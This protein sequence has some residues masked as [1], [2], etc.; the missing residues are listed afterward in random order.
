MDQRR[1]PVAAAAAAALLAAGGVAMTRPASAATAG[2]SVSYTVQ[3]QWSDGFGAKVAITNLG[4]P[5]SVWS[6]TWRFDAGQKVT[7]AWNATATQSGNSVTA[8]NVSWN[9]SIATNG[10]ASD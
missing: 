10:T 2:C 4:T 6:L 1:A 8:V 9:A 7:Q 5:L 3:S